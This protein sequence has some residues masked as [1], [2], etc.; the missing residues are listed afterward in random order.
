MMSLVIEAGNSREDQQSPSTQTTIPTQSTHVSYVAR[1]LLLWS[2]VMSETCPTHVPCVFLRIC[3]VSAYR[4]HFNVAVSVQHSIS[5][6][7]HLPLG[8]KS[9]M[10]SFNNIN[11]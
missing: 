11:T 1:T 6:T 7:Q 4:I 3:Y 5:C 8:I 10:T 2:R 9:H